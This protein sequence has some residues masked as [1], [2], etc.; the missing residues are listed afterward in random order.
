MQT[1]HTNSTKASQVHIN[2][3]E[4][5]LGVHNEGVRV[6]FFG[7]SPCSARYAMTIRGDPPSSREEA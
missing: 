5:M 2:L 4:H 3:R 6:S 7:L 1:V